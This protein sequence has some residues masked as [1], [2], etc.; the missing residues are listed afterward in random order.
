MSVMLS[1][2]LYQNNDQNKECK[3]AN[4]NTVSEKLASWLLC[5][6]TDLINGMS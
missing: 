3:I 6:I 2:I 5:L 4:D 1:N